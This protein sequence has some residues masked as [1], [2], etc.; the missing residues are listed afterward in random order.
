MIQM[1]F[2]QLLLIVERPWRYVEQMI[3]AQIKKAQLRIE[4][5]RR[6]DRFDFVVFDD[7]SQNGWIQCNG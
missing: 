1:Q 6:I 4:L 2:L 7:Q 5:Y 3:V